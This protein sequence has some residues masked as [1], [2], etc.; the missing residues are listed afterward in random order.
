MNI[1]KEKVQPERQR[2]NDKGEY[3]LRKPLPEK[4]WIYADKR[5]ALY[6][7]ITSMKRV[8]A[9]PLHSKYMICAWEPTNI[10]FSH[11]L[12]VIATSTDATFALLNVHSMTI[13]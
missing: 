1:L 7:T 3:V 6:S 5:P 9:V 10:V 4:W 8:L 13:G 11:A 12:S 2:K